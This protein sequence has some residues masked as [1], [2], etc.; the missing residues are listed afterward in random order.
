MDFPSVKASAA[1]LGLCAAGGCGNVAPEPNR[2]E[3]SGEIIALS[4]GEAGADG[5]CVTC[6]GLEGEGDRAL[7]PRLA[8]LDPGYIVRQLELYDAGQR[9]DPQ[10]R[11]IAGR[12][13]NAARMK[14][15]EH[16]SELPAHAADDLRKLRCVPE[17]SE[18][19]HRGD[20]ARGLP[21]CASCHGDDGR[22]VGRGNPPLAGQPAAYLERQ[23][24]HWRAGRRYGDPLG[25]MRR[26]S[27]HLHEEELA[28]LADYSAGL[29][30]DRI[31]PELRAAC[32][33][34]RRAD[35][36]SGA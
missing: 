29:T 3:Q 36:R 8:G 4:G 18:L 12:L 11:W 32:P 17:I 33:P 14:L 26:I 6:H 10:M 25:A 15:A 19:Y 7:V 20:P 16:Y 13:D 21:S 34:A 23:L 1:L 35:P 31:R 24:R 28:P 5:A 22:G 2:F 9:S 27:Q 30:D